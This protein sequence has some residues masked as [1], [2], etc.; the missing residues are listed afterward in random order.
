MQTEAFVKGQVALLVE[1]SEELKSLSNPYDVTLR[2]E[3]NINY[4]YDT[5]YYNGSYYNY[6]GV[7]PI[8]TCILP[9][10]LLTGKYLPLYLW[11]LLFMTIAIFA[12]YILAIS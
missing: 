12:L 9:F 3:K 4:L 6:F 11:N 7:A 1:P 10:R 2:N 5:A 8:L